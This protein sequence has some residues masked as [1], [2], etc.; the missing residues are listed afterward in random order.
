MPD[1]ADLIQIYF[2]LK[3]VWAGLTSWKHFLGSA[4]YVL[5]LGEGGEFTVGLV[6]ISVFRFF[7]YTSFGGL[8]YRSCWCIGCVVTLS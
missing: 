8:G 6:E 5:W 1:W 4:V 2:A 3:L 7:A